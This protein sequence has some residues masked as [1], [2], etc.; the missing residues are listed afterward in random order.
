MRIT[1]AMLLIALATAASV[2]AH[3]RQPPTENKGMKAD[4]LSSFALGRQGLDDYAQRQI[5]SAGSPSSRAA[6]WG[7]TASARR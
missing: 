1:T 7:S 5:R 4:V 6:P 2:P 3:A